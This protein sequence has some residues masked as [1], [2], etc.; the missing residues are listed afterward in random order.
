MAGFDAL[1]AAHIEQIG[2]R[3]P[4]AWH[5]R[6]AWAVTPSQIESKV[7][8]GDEAIVFTSVLEANG[9]IHHYSDPY[10]PWTK[11]KARANGLC[12]NRTN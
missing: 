12:F 11:K 10:A 2:V 9:A 5:V 3:Y 6:Y 7:F 8:F 4:D 1:Y